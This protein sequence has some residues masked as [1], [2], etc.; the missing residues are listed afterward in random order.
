MKVICRRG[1]FWLWFQGRVYN[2]R[3]GITAG[4]QKVEKPHLKCSL[5]VKCLTW[6]WGQ[7]VCYQ[8]PPSPSVLL[9]LVRLQVP[10]ALPSLPNSTLIMN[11][12]LKCSSLGG[13]LS[14]KL[15]VPILYFLTLI[16]FS[17]SWFTRIRVHRHLF[18]DFF[19][20]TMTY[21]CAR[22]NLIS[23]NVDKLYHSSGPGFSTAVGIFN[24]KVGGRFCI[25]LMCF[26]FLL[27]FLCV[28]MILTLIT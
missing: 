24:S 15:Q 8:S 10:R 20:C 1:L 21:F 14:F 2:G 19:K 28:Y 7:F 25:F 11:Q 5:E 26:S 27:L 12:V 18:S 17:V 13:V 9:P 16:H 4:C 22:G 6:K 3:G 23:G